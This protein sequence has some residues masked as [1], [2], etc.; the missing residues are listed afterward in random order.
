MGN[1]S[2]YE[3]SLILIIISFYIYIFF[4]DSKFQ[5]VLCK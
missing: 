5:G 1:S 2:L 4:I 3:I